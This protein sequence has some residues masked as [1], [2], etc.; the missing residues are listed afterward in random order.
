MVVFR[1][2]ARG[3]IIT[4]AVSGYRS[5]KDLILPL[6]PL[7]VITGANGTGKSSLYRSL[8]LLGEIAQ[9]R[10]ISSLAAE[11]GLPSTLW[12]GPEQLSR[13]MKSGDMAITGT[14]RKKPVA[15][16]LGFASEDYGF[17][18]DMGLPAL[19][20]AFSGDPEI[21]AETVWIGEKL[22][23][24][25][26]IAERSGPSVRVRSESG[27]WAQ[28]STTLP[29]YD[30]MMT[31]S[32]DPR[33]APELLI[34]RDRMRDWRFYDQ[35][36][37]DRDAP[38][39]S[40]QVGTRTPV[41]AGDGA[42]LA[43]AIQTIREIGDDRGFDE[44]IEDAFPAS[45]VEIVVN[46]GMFSVR[47]YQKGLLRPLSAAELSDGTLRY[48]L[49]VAALLTPRP[50]SLMVLNEPET[51]LHPDLIPPLAR[52]IADA[53]GRSQI[54]VVSHN[55]ILTSALEAAG[56]LTH[57]LVKETGETVVPDA[58]PAS[59]AWPKR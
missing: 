9:G 1:R 18:V 46:D 52:L 56:G 59:W 22:R 33:S 53:A 57:R 16:K 34:L 29:P 48:L 50:P 13:G 20:S 51:S 55:E 45:S 5:L 23:R 10:A 24:N 27:S 26:A 37:T 15:L 43:A 49:L 19:V 35:L 54:V 47:M 14:V 12:A 42:D 31:H 30:S 58:E 28:A 3:M 40:Q 32:A 21:K 6:S 38:A 8:R 17:A 41:L 39:R 7:T 11:G 36:R 44:M 4:L 2:L 25:N